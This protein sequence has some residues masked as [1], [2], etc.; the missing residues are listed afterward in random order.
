MNKKLVTIILLVIVASL[1]TIAYAI[2]TS[3]SPV[4][5]RTGVVTSTNCAVWNVASEQ[6]G[7]TSGYVVPAGPGDVL[8]N[9]SGSAGV[10]TV[11]TIGIAVPTFALPSGYAVIAV[12]PHTANPTSTSCTLP[13]VGLSSGSQWHFTT[14]GDYDYCAAYDSST[15]DLASFSL[16]WA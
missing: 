15:G 10:I 13:S 3:Q 4:V 8:F 11:S 7:S 2:L 14:T 1:V 16:S 9:C 12:I 5:H 6:P